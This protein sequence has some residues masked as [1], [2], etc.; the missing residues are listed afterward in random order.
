[1]TN[2]KSVLSAS[3]LILALSCSKENLQPT[4]HS[5]QTG[6][7]ENA[8]EDCNPGRWFGIY[9]NGYTPGYN[10]DTVPANTFIGNGVATLTNSPYSY[11]Y[12]S[13]QLPIPSCH[14]FSGDSARVEVT[15][16]NPASG[17]ITDYDVSFFLIGSKDTAH[18]TFIGYRQEFTSVGIG[19]KQY[20]NLPQ[21]VHL[22]NEFTTIALELKGGVLK[23][24]NGGTL[25]GSIPYRK[26]DRIGNLRNINLGFKG[27]G[28][29]DMVK[30]FNTATGNQ[31]MQED[32][33]IDG[34]SSVIWY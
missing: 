10:Y 1:M 13:I 22:F 3:L 15:L 7:A 12:T 4:N 33:N 8:A 9:A 31:I 20:Q 23:V 21:L 16:K 5:L 14:T 6:S 19:S 27:S 32:F 29:I 30:V 11:Y 18:V 28:T 25:I 2:F 34:E 26:A 17:G 24:Y